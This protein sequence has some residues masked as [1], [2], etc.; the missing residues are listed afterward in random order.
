VAHHNLSFRGRALWGIAL[1]HRKLGQLAA[2]HEYLLQAKDA[3]EAAEEL[4]DL[5]SVLKN[6]GD[7]RLEQHQPREA[8]RHFHHALRVTERVGNRVTHASTLTE[9]ARTHL[10]L[11]HTQEAAAFAAQ[12]LDEAREVGDP[13][14]VAEAQVVLARVSHRREEPRDAI[15]LYKEALAAFQA[16]DMREK[17]ADVAGELGMLLRDRGAHARAAEYLAISLAADRA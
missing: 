10:V 2:A 1:A 8:L 15:R 17:A 7:L 16:R 14:E 3:F 9:I 13:V 5:A 11:G 12:A 4:K 6:L